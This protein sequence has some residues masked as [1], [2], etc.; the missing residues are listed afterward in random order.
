MDALPSARTSLV[1]CTIFF[2]SSLSI[3]LHR[4]RVTNIRLDGMIFWPQ[5]VS[6]SLLG[7]YSYSNINS[8]DRVIP[9]R[10]DIPLP[11]QPPYTAFVG[12]LA[13]DLVEGDL[14][15]FFQNIKVRM[16][17]YIFP[18]ISFH[19]FLSQSVKIIKDREEKPKGFGYVEFEDLDGL[20]AALAINGQV[21]VRRL[22]SFT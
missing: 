18:L 9:V 7:V 12:N 13:F 21:R 10:D 2:Y 3:Q 16:Y 19:I 8:A 22:L 14:E 5:G 4:R 17:R 20:K 6:S 1:K 15:Q 11:S